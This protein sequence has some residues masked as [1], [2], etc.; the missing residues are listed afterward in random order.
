MFLK[1]SKNFLFFLF[2]LTISSVTMSADKEF[3]YTWTPE[4]NVPDWAFFRAEGR[5]LVES[6][7]HAMAYCTKAARMKKTA[8]IEEIQYF[9]AAEET[10]K[11]LG[12][13]RS[14]AQETVLAKFGMVGDIMWIRQ[15]WTDFLDQRLSNYMQGWDFW[16]GN[17]ETPIATSVR[18]P[19]LLPDT[20]WFNS[21]PEL[22]TSFSRKDG[23]NLFA[24]VGFSNNHVLDQGPVGISETLAFL[25]QLKVLTSGSRLK[26][27]D[28]PY[29]T[30]S[31]NGVKF[32]FYSA[33]WGLNDPPSLLKS[34]YPINV[35][36]GLAPP[37]PLEKVDISQIKSVLSDMSQEGCDIKIISLHWGHEH[38]LFPS[39]VQ[40]QLARKI[41][42]SGADII[43]GHH[44]HV[45]Q[46]FEIL[47]VNGYSEFPSKVMLHDGAGK[48]RKALI[49]YSLGNFSTAMNACY[50]VQ[51]GQTIV[52]EVIKRADGSIDW[53]LKDAEQVY[54][55]PKDPSTGHLKL[56]LL[57]DHK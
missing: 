25:E 16:L 44:P 29:V 10:I 55:E 26:A 11:S 50:E 20:R 18:V 24:A 13:K 38:E 6:L 43:M 42:E 8:P 19:H 9:R 23:T 4:T 12:Q 48:P 49:L 52:V 33:G 28:K 46:P 37:Q 2:F 30:F 53:N 40:M 32:G 15:G 31:K 34:P 54:N 17:L 35:V 36:P 47:P 41:V 51:V 5:T 21:A 7:P 3:P 56:M 45:V 14:P 22:L 27:Q 57:R 1:N 39:P